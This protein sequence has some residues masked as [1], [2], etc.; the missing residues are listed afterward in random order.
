MLFSILKK[1]D[2]LVP[3]F[4]LLLGVHEWIWNEPAT[5][6]KE[7]HLI[8][9]SK[10][11]TYIQTTCVCV[12]DIEVKIRKNQWKTF[13]MFFLTFCKKNIIGSGL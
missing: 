9:E 1:G 7:T 12:C 6:K 13:P 8:G 2:L 5:Q 11:Q 4:F 10:S 3:L